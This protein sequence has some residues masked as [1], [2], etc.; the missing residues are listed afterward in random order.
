MAWWRNLAG[1]LALALVAAAVALGLPALDRRLPEAR[2]LTPGLL[3]HVGGGVRLVPPAGA[4]L[5][6]ARARPGRRTGAA[7]FLLGPVRLAVVATPFARDLAAAATRLRDKITARR[8]SQVTG[9][10]QP[11]VTAAGL[12]GLAGGYAGPD[13]I[14]RYVVFVVSGVAVEVTV[15]GHDAELRATLDHVDASVRSLT[16]RPPR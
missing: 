9:P 14:G 15:S 12:T 8:G 13:R 11:Y 4:L 7:L 5:D 1:S 3:Y 16:V 10:E 6:I 2:P